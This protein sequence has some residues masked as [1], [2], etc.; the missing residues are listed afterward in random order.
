LL[1]LF[2]FLVSQ[3]QA[4]FVRLALSQSC[5]ICSICKQKIM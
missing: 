4:Q 2:H 5:K 1:H 3:A